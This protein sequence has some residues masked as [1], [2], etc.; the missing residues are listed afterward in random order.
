MTLLKSPITINTTKLKNRLVLPPM[1][2]AKSNNGTVTPELIDYYKEKA[3][4]GYIGLIITEHSYVSLEGK[5]GK[6]QLSMADDECIKDLKK[7]TQT[8]H[9]NHTKVFAQINH[10]GSAAKKEDTGYTPLAPSAIKHPRA[11]KE[12]LPKEMNIEDIQKVIQDFAKAAL[13]A[14]EAGFDGV[15]IHSAHGYLLNQFFSPI[16][17]HRQDNYNGNTLNGRIRLHLEI[18]H[19][20]REVV[21]E[22]FPI[23]LRLG[24]C[25]YMENGITLEDSLYACK[26]FKKAGVDLLDI[27]GGFSL[28]INPNSKEQGYFSHLTREIKKAV[29]IP[30]ILTGGITDAH[31]AET[32]L[33]QNKADMIGVGRAMLKDSNWAKNAI[34]SL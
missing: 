28:Y 14:K 27:S 2:T 6:N 33:E 10:A 29:N 20:I 5:A 3:N 23:A 17:N 30:V 19:A 11:N 21:K 34:L 15:E 18:I 1:A 24:A 26:E 4:G 12:N 25:D 22:D 32:L 16:T 9:D 7:L 13:R 31:V 8:I